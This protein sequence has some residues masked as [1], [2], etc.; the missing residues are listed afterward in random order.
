MGRTRILVGA[1][2]IVDRV[3]VV[4]DASNDA[5]LGVLLQLELTGLG[6]LGK[7]IDDLMSGGLAGYRANPL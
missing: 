3:I 4:D 7:N 1:Q 5:K 6:Q 2:E